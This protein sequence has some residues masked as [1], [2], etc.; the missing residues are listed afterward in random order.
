VT[1]APKP[2]RTLVRRR[3]IL[4]AIWLATGAAVVARATQVQVL[5]AGRWREAAERQHSTTRT[6]P[7]ARGRILDRNGVPLAESREMVRVSIAPGELEDVKAA[8][9]LLR[10]E[11]GLSAREAVRHTDRSKR[12]SVIPG[13]FEPSDL[14]ALRELHGVYLESAHQRSYPRGDLARGVLGAVVDGAGLGGIEEAYDEVLRG[15][16]G[17]QIAARDNHGREIPGQSLVVETPVPGGDV[18]LTLDIG[19]QEIVQEALLAALDSTGARG[20]DVL[21]TDPR[22]GEILAMASAQGGKLDGLSA[23]N[24]PYEP[25]STLKPFTVAAILQNEVGALG[26]SID[27]HGGVWMVGGRPL[28]DVHSYGTLT[29]GD[30]LRVSSNVG[31][32]MAA[33]ALGQGTQYQALRDFGFGVQAGLPLPGEVAGTLR[34]PDQWTARSAASLAIGYEIA[35]TPLQM[36][37]AYG[38][39]ANGGVLVEPRLLREVRAQD[40]SVVERHPP[41]AVRRVVSPDVAHQVAGVLVDV[42]E[43]G[44]GTQARMETFQVAG[45]TG[46]ARAYTPGDGY[47]GGHIASFGAFFPADDPQLVVFVKLESPKGAYYGGETA[48]PVT[49][50]TME[51]ALA[52]RQTTLDRRALLGSVRTEHRALLPKAPTAPSQASAV[53]FASANLTPLQPTASARRARPTAAAADHAEATASTPLAD[54]ELRIPDVSGLSPRLAARKLHAAGLRVA[55][56]GGSTVMGSRP[57]AGVRATRGETV[58][59]ITRDGDRR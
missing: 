11:L 25:G 27:T 10:R 23:I 39:L 56:D 1:P 41:R 57:T 9:A 4:L 45:K 33:Q 3:Q 36:A 43:E 40:G 31:V 54:G 8:R 19:L 7:A 22:T 52:A 53:R 5:Q 37:M 15:I 18:V 14:Q 32:A 48:A 26:D 51:A 24:S 50:A 17:S 16:P 44:T 2:G 29:L 59:L 28:R 12:W 46:T 21:V 6:V 13:R 20:G 30:A 42:V 55:W 38:A 49:R 47:T 35:A 34:R 58:R